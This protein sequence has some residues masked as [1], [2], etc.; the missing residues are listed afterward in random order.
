[1]IAAEALRLSRITLTHGSGAIPVV[2]FGTLIPDHVATTQAPKAGRGDPMLR[3]YVEQRVEEVV[4]W[5]IDDPFQ[6]GYRRGA[7]S[8]PPKLL[9]VIV[10]SAPASVRRDDVRARVE[11]HR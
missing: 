11:A 6:A 5:R 8:T 7:L 10:G 2:G 4:Y 1:M 3:S 9:S